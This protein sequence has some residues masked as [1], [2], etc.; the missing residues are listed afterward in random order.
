MQGM[1]VPPGGSCMLDWP[2]SQQILICSQEIEVRERK[3]VA[4][5]PLNLHAEHAV[6]RRG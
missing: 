4:L 2:I 1:P 6:A 5:A 3:P